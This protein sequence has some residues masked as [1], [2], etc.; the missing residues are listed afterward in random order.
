V[1]AALERK[2]GNTEMP[3]LLALLCDRMV[4]RRMWK[5]AAARAGASASDGPVQVASRP[6]S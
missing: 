2:V 1:D 3:R 6:T 4:N 5:R